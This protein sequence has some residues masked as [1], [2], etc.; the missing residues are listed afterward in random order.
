MSLCVT[1]L[2]C[3]SVLAWPTATRLPSGRCCRRK[4]LSLIPTEASTLSFIHTGKPTPRAIAIPDGVGRDIRVLLGTYYTTYSSTARA[5]CEGVFMMLSGA[6]LGP[7]VAL[8]PG[9][10]GRRAK[11]R[12]VLW[13]GF[14][15]SR[16]EDVE[17]RRGRS[18][19][20]MVK[21]VGTAGRKEGGAAKG[22]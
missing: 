10:H 15:G 6:R 17:R 5:P 11:A 16:R 2:G 13:E 3:P 22:A 19:A 1:A 18:E 9:P 21:W 20:P 8:S 7:R 12:G 4:A 14:S